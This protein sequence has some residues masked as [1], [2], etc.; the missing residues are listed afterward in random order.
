MI[1]PDAE[2]EKYATIRAELEESGYRDVEHET[3]RPGRRV[4]HRGER[5][6]EAYDHGTG[7][8]LA[9]MEKP[10]SAW[11]A[12]WGGRDIELIVLRDRPMFEDWSRLSQVA[13]YHV[14]V[15]DR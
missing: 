14:Q 12:D 2:R 1:I 8:I 10:N 15:V 9:V 13:D 7:V 4:R 3:L 5:Y 6:P 11:S